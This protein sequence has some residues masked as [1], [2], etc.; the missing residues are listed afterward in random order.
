MKKRHIYLIL[1]LVY[2][3]GALVS[4]RPYKDGCGNNLGYKPGTSHL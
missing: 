1:L 4:C 3:A 2:L